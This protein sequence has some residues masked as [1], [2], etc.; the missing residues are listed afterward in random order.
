MGYLHSMTSKAKTVNQ[1]LQSLPADRRAALSAVCKVVLD[2]LP[3]V[4]L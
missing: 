4:I 2:N 1:Y 3:K